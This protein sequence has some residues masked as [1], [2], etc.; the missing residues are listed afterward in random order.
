[1]H[2]DIKPQN[3]LFSS[4]SKLLKY[5]DF[6]LART[7][8]IPL[9][10]YTK[11]IETLWYRAPELMLGDSK[12][13]FNV[14]VWALGCIFA[15]M[16]TKKPLFM[17]DSQVDQIFK[18]FNTLGT[19]NEE[20][21]GGLT[22]LPYWKEGLP[23]FKAGGLEKFVPCLDVVG[24]DLMKKMLC[25]DPRKRISAKEAMTHPFLKDMI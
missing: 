25:L 19:P 8:D 14:D 24:M 2:R 3:L 21:W 7:I 23:R 12:Y 20:N 22:Q 13:S 9:K 1:M 16:I 10:K 15:E 5:A 6:G 11:E 18:I 17:G 4:A